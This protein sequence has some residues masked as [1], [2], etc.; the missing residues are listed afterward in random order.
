MTA[1]ERKFIIWPRS[2][3]SRANED[4]I[5]TKDIIILVSQKG[6]YL[7]YNLSSDFAI[8][9]VKWSD[10][11]RALKIHEAIRMHWFTNLV[12]TF[13]A[14]N[15]TA[16]SICCCT[17]L[18]AV[19]FSSLCPPVRRSALLLSSAFPRPSV[20]ILD[21]HL[22][23]ETP[24]NDWALNFTEQWIHHRNYVKTVNSQ[25]KVT[26]SRDLWK[27]NQI[28]HALL[29]SCVSGYTLALV[30]S[31]FLTMHHVNWLMNYTSRQYRFYHSL[32][33]V[34]HSFPILS[35]SI[36]FYKITK[37]VRA[38]WLAET[39]VCMRVC[40]HGCV[41]LSCTHAT[42]KESLNFDWSEFWLVSWE[43]PLSN[44]C[45]RKIRFDK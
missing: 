25:L 40:K 34:V 20:I 45:C 17:T 30:S 23:C 7:F 35:L 33:S 38:L 36:T 12:T 41:T 9:D 44:L 43:I 1:A 2:E 19:P 22:S 6:V 26:E 4:N 13:N 37:I 27:V 39:R 28:S 42:S 29:T 31:S 8:R 14:T 5:S 24:Q 15:F 18:Q 11:S 3:A 21:L 10:L 16:L 32:R